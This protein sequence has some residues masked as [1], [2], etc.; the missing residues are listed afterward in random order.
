MKQHSN[1]DKSHAHTFANFIHFRYIF[2]HRSTRK[3]ALRNILTVF[4][5]LG[6]R[7]ISCKSLADPSECPESKTT[8]K[9]VNSCPLSSKEWAVAASKMNCQNI[10]N[11]CSSFVYHCVMNSNMTRMI[12]VC[13][14]VTNILEKKCTEYNFQGEVIQRNLFADCHSCPNFYFSNETFNYRECYKLVNIKDTESIFTSSKTTTYQTTPLPENI[15]RTLPTESKRINATKHSTTSSHIFRD[16]DRPIPSDVIV[17]FVCLGLSNLGIVSVPVYLYR[18][19]YWGNK[20][21]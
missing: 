1:R 21:K 20:E 12:E 17:L 8:I 15:I 6:F 7:L 11:T 18:R 2:V 4:C 10:E 13:A 9:F 3:M 14:P 16:K 19:K 5:L